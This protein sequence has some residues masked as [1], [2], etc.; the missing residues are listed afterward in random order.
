MIAD[1]SKLGTYPG[2]IGGTFPGE[3]KPTTCYVC[4]A[5]CT[6]AKQSM[7]GQILFGLCDEHAHYEPYMTIT[8]TGVG[9]GIGLFDPTELEE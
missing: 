3:L 5:T 6:V 1:V 8:T 9:A 7:M 2:C 4:G